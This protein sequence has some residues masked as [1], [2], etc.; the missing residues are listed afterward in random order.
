ME[1][2]PPDPS[3]GVPDPF[4]PKLSPDGEIQVSFGAWE[5]RMSH[6]ILEPV[7]TRMRDGKA[8][9]SL[10]GSEWDGGG[11]PPSFPARDRVELHLRHYPE[12]DVRYDLVVDV[13][14]ERCWFLGAEEEAV[15]LAKA[16]ELLSGAFQRHVERSAPQYLA[17][18]LCPNCKSPLYPGW[19]DKLRGRSAVKCEVCSRT[20]QLS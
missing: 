4:P 10:E 6:W 9:L 16:E 20:W 12:G 11:V 1:A 3:A 15:P 13:K 14:A 18:G 8:V 7:V 2:S 19:L 5:A 17:Q